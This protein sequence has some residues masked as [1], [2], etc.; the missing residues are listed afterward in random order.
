MN[1]VPSSYRTTAVH[2]GKSQANI[3]KLLARFGVVDVRFTMLDSRGEVIC[4]FN[5]PTKLDDKDVIIGVRIRV[6]LPPA[7]R[8]K[9][10]ERIKNQA[11]RALFYYLKT[12]FEALQFG[13]VEFIQEFL[14]HVVI[15]DKSGHQGTVYQALE[16]KLKL[17]FVEGK[18]Q[19]VLLEDLR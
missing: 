7:G 6:P 4:E 15:S 11:H 10:T 13:L 16:Q 17:G 2:W 3:L 18:Q 5:Y 19:S 1:R 8:I 14:P 9:D 12:K